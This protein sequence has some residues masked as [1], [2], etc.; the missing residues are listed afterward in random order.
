M[1]CMKNLLSCFPNDIK[2]EV[3]YFAN[4][5]NASKKEYICEALRTFNMIQRKIL[6]FRKE[7]PNI[8]YEIKITIT[9]VDD[10]DPADI[11][12]AA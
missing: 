7:N 11:Q 3:E 8:R 12:I 9:P 2:N 1:I 6:K 5:I 10:N 4:I